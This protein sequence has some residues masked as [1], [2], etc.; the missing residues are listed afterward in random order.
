MKKAYKQ[1]LKQLGK[2][3]K[4]IRLSQKMTQEALADLC[5]IDVRTIQRIEKGENGIGINILFAISEALKISLPEFFK[6][7]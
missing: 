2:K 6:K 5:E 7:D 3:I 1:E 4:A